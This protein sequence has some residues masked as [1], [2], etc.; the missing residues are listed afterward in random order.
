MDMNLGREDERTEFKESLAQLDKG[1]RSLTAML[2]RHGEGTVY[3]G[4][5]DDGEVIGI[6]VGDDTLSRIRERIRTYVEPMIVADIGEHLSDDGKSYII[7]RSKGENTPYM[8]D[9]R[10]FI[11]NVSSDE[12][13]SVEIARKM[14][15]SGNTDVLCGSRSRNQNLTFSTLFMHLDN[16]GRHTENNRTYYGNSHLLNDDGEFNNMAYILSDQNDLCMQVVV[17]DGTDR[18]TMLGRSDYGHRSLVSS[19]M[20]VME[21]VTSMNSTRVDLSTGYRREEN[22][23]DTIAFREA[24]MN[25]CVHNNWNE[26]RPPSVH[27]FDDR[28]EIHSFGGIPFAMSREDFYHGRSR[29]VNRNLFQLFIG[30]GLSESSGYGVPRIVKS[31][32]REAIDVDDF[33][34]TVTIPFAFRPDWVHGKTVTDS[35]AAILNDNQRRILGILAENPGIR[36]EDVSKEVNM[37]LSGVKKVVSKLKRLGLIRNDGNTRNTRWII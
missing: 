32:G 17:F 5:D 2:N 3:F 11:R 26:L 36:L 34:V 25:A 27:I 8:F 6:T 7:I 20:T 30:L 18:S 37:S 21:K 1:I 33:T 14:L 16:N 10:I 15:M 19:A 29:P 22:L 28:M 9:G 31:Y 24:W 13:A 12:R 35:R 4:V 23:F